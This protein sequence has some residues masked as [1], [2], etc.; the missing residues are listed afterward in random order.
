[1]SKTAETSTDGLTRTVVRTF[2][3]K[4]ALDEFKADPARAAAVES[5]D[6]YNT[7]NGTTTA[8]TVVT[9]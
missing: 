9:V 7:A 6:A 1:L 4:A 3:N 5:R 8:T 2:A